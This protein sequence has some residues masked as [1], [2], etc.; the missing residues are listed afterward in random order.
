MDLDLDLDSAVYLGTDPDLYPRSQT[1]ADADSDLGQ[2]LPP[3]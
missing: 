1:N 3:L 2:T